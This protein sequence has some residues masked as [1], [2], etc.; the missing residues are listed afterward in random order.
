MKMKEI[1]KYVDRGWV[2]IPISTNSKVCTIKWKQYQD[3]KPRKKEILEWIKNNGENGNVG[4]ITGEVSGI[5]VIDVD[6]KEAVDKITSMLSDD[7]ECGLVVTP[8]GGQHFYFAYTPELKTTTNRNLKIDIRNDGAYVLLPPSKINGKEYA[9]IS[10]PEKLSKVP[11]KLV[12]FLNSRDSNKYRFTKDN[13]KLG[14]RDSGLF[15]LALVLAKGGMRYDEIYDALKPYADMCQPPFPDDALRIKITSALKRVGEKGSTLV[16]EVREYVENVSGVFSFR[17]VCQDLNV[18]ST[19]DKKNISKILSDMV[20]EGILEKYG[21]WNATYR[22][23]ESELEPINLNALKPGK[24]LDLIFP[25]G[26]EKKF[27]VYPKNIIIIAG[28][29][30]VGKTLF[31]LNFVKMNQDKYQIHYFNSEM[32]EEELAIRLSQFKTK[33]KANFYCR[34]NN[35]ADVIKPN[36]I[37]VIDYLEIEDEF[38]KIGQQINKIHEK[39]GKG[40]CIIGIQKDSSKLLGRGASFGLEKPRVYLSMDRDRLTI[41]KA[42]N[43]ATKDNP[44]FKC[45]DY[46]IKGVNIETIG[47]WYDYVP[48]ID[49]LNKKE[50]NRY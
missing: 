32:S 46:K 36:D 50:Y 21:K 18:F 39:L 16:E 45:I 33:W 25:F 48:P 5:T 15:H 22:K 10:L 34:S 44:N 23:K 30:N 43:W 26:L 3:E 19:A 13:L 9:W 37:N 6:S 31:M 35:F 27:A 49:K 4:I 42:K 12:E 17:N 20:D 8:R 7:D 1:K 14:G 29:Q 47:E 24:P 41:V 38:W 28:V 40:V 11:D 2:V